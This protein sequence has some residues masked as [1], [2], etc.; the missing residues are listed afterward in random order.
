VLGKSNIK[1]TK[2][3]LRNKNFEKYDLDALALSSPKL[4]KHIIKTKFN[5]QSID[6]SN[7]IAVKELNTALLR[8]YYG[9]NNWIF[10]KENLC[11]PIPG[12]ADYIH[13]VADL[14]AENNLGKIPKGK[15]VTCLDIGIGAS[16]IYPIIGVTEYGWQFLGSDV[17][18]RSIASAQKIINVN[19]SLKH[20]IKC[21]LQKNKKI[22]FE[23]V[24]KKD[25][26]FDLVV[27]NPPFH[28]SIEEAQ[29]ASKRKIKNLTGEKVALAKLNF[30]GINN[31]LIYEGGE[32]NF[33]QK[34]ILESKIYSKNCAWFT[35]LVSKESNLN[36]LRNSLNKAKVNQI[37]IIPMGTGNK[38][39]RILA[40]T[41]LSKKELSIWQES[42]WK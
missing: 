28:S 4:K 31:E 13:Y 20:M 8:Y 22:I 6:F 25:S 3:H 27:C 16:C 29:K 41:F 24:L 42:R 9:I 7:P 38:S 2:L 11:P 19:D 32:F 23:G 34:M 33:I 40:W 18:A 17:D 36:G 5:T 30:G 37:K 15:K 39:T 12:R 26:Q 1:K 35:T 14:L 21:T 10:P